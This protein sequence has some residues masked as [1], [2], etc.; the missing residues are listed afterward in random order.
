MD[1]M[2]DQRQKSLQSRNTAGSSA[3]AHVSIRVQLP[4]INFEENGCKVMYCPALDLSGYGMSDDEAKESFRITLEEF[5]RYT[6]N[7][8]TLDKVL[9]K[10]GWVKKS[11]RRIS[12]PTMDIMLSKNRNFRN[13]FNKY[14][15]TKT[16]ASIAIPAC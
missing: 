11:P 12:P 10:L 6:I 1:K 5:F 3:A 4:I 14:S 16:N 15:F 9:T 2:T 8:K 13:I 7:K